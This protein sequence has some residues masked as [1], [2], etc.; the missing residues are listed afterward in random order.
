M[1]KKKESVN[2]N[3]GDLYK[4]ITI[5][6]PQVLFEIDSKGKLT[7]SNP[8]GFEM[9]GYSQEE[10]DRGLKAVNMLVKEDRNSAKKSIATILMGK[11][12]GAQ[13][14]TALRKDGSKFPVI[15]YTSPILYKKIPVGIRGML[16]DITERKKMEGLLLNLYKTSTQLQETKTVNDIIDMALSTFNEF[17]FDRV[18]FYLY[19]HIE[20]ILI[21]KKAIG[22]RNNV[23]S[24]VRIPVTKDHKKTYYCINEK[25]PIIDHGVKLSEYKDM[26]GKK[27]ITESASLPLISS[28]KVIGIISVDNKYSKKIIKEDNLEFLMTFTNQIATT[29]ENAQLYDKYDKRLKKLSTLYDVSKLI[30]STLDLE[31]VLNLIVLRIVKIMKIPTCSLLLIDDQKK[32]LLPKSLYD[33]TNTYVKRGPVPIK[34]SISGEVINTLS[35]IFITDVN[36]S[37]QLHYKEWAKKAK[38]KTLLSIPL[39]IENKGIGNHISKSSSSNH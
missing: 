29:I 12:I 11:K 36:K 17:G 26:L 24:K 31:K 16:V 9:F 30:T 27:G 4:D 22:T 13:E 18:R 20:N 34:K 7:F 19:D 32:Y 2:K 5:S 15:V 38:I 35:P 39:K 8:K 1:K 10:L 25:R 37:K 3:N 33:S 6:S 21:G 14:Y 23:I 28:G